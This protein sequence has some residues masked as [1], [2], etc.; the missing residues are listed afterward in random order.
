[1]NVVDSPPGTTSPSRPSSC[2][3]LRTSTTSAPS[4]RSAAVCSRKFPWTARTPIFTFEMLVTRQPL[5][6]PRAVLDYDEA[7]AQA[8]KAPETLAA[9]DARSASVVCAG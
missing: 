9:E 7:L 8:P 3:G 1:M 6:D 4:R 5:L 2:A